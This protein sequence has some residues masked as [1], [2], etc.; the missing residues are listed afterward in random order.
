MI[1]FFEIHSRTIDVGF[2]N[3][4]TKIFFFWEIM[5]NTGLSDTDHFFQISVTEGSITSGTQHKLCR[6]D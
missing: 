1:D 2:N 5:V 4:H 6:I 3:F